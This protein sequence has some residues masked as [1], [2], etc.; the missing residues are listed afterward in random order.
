K[1]ALQLLSNMNDK[2][3][4]KKRQYKAALDIEYMKKIINF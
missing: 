1:F 2:H 4:L 3:S